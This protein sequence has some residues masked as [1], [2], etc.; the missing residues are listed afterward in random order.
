MIPP[1]GKQ[2]R[3]GTTIIVGHPFPN[4]AAQEDAIVNEVGGGKLDLGS[5]LIPLTLHPPTHIR[6]LQTSHPSGTELTMRTTRPGFA[7]RPAPH[8]RPVPL[9]PG[10]RK[11]F[12][13]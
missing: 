11:V 8:S 10:W 12:I 7:T 6:G 4:L 2:K 9:L 1:P 5:R 13:E 3:F